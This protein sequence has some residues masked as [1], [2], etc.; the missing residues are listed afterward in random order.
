[1][2]FMSD[3]CHDQNKEYNKVMSLLQNLQD[4]VATMSDKSETLNLIKNVMSQHLKDMKLEE[5][6]RVSYCCFLILI[7]VFSFTDADCEQFDWRI[8]FYQ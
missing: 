5:K 6:V 1:M 3:K 4:Q 8:R 7:E 2:A